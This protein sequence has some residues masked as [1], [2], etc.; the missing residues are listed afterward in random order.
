[1][2]EGRGRN[3]LPRVVFDDL[4]HEL[5]EETILIEVAFRVKPDLV[6]RLRVG[7]ALG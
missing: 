6:F 7:K 5:F 3:W 1:M 2:G 4:I